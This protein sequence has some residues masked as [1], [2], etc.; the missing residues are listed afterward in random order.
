MATGGEVQAMTSKPEYVVTTASK[1][2]TLSWKVKFRDADMA[3]AMI[4]E[5]LKV[6]LVVTAVERRA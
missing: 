1:N 6:G 4:A 5:A 2:G 3:L